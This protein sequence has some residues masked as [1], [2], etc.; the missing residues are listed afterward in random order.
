MNDRTGTWLIKYISAQ[1]GDCIDSFVFLV[2]FY[3]VHIFA[4]F[5][6]F[7]QFSLYFFSEF[8][9]DKFTYSWLQDGP[10]VDYI[11]LN[12]LYFC[13][14]IRIIFIREFRFIEN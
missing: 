10:G 13:K 5:F 14:T 1:N 7:L 3:I 6:F 12:G 9:L 2:M 11:L 4:F 8:Q